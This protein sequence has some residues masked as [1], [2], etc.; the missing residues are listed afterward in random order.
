[1]YE[2]IKDAAESSTVD[3]EGLDSSEL[4]ELVETRREKLEEQCK[5]WVKYGEYVTIEINTEAG[6]ATVC[7]A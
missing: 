6:T 3:L 1:M 4:E 5:P 7:K 2:S